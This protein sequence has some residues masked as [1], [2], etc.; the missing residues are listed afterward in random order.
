VPILH[1]VRDVFRK[2]LQEEPQK[3]EFR[4][5]CDFVVS[6]HTPFWALNNEKLKNFL[7]VNCD[8]SIPDESTLRRNYISKCYNNILDS[9]VEAE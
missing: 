7:E 2:I 6:T 1:S 9:R 5:L 8:C 4:Y 3:D